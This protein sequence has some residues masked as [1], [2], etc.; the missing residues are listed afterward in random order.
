M[1]VP[2][3]L[4]KTAWINFFEHH[5][6]S[7]SLKFHRR[8]SGIRRWAYSGHLRRIFESTGINVSAQGLGV[9][10]PEQIKTRKY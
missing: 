7:L 8:L 2:L 5:Q 3:V 10:E 9:T 4:Q 6:F 1:V